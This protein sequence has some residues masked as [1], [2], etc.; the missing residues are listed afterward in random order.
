M[1]EETKKYDEEEKKMQVEVIDNKE[2]MDS[3]EKEL[4]I[5]FGKEEKDDGLDQ[6]KVSTVLERGKDELY[7]KIEEFKGKK[8]R[9]EKENKD[10]EVVEWEIQKKKNQ[11]L[12][13]ACKVNNRR[14][15]I[16]KVRKIE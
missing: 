7:K 15:E 6:D 13:M 4:T 11:H 1:K 14:D 5:E 16:E 9:L 8:E 2:E 10:L 3:L 12:E